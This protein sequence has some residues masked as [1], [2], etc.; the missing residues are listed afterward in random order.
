VRLFVAVEIAD[1]V[2][3]RLA[4]LSAELQKR[5]ARQAR[6]A[7]LT[8]VRPERMHLT[9]RFIGEVDEARTAAIAAALAPPLQTP[10]FDIR[11]AGTGA[12][13]P[14]GRP[15]VLWAGI[16]EGI[17]G[18]QA[19]ERE[20]TERLSGCGVPPEDRPYNP[21]LTLARVR[22]PGGLRS[23]PLFE[24][25]SDSFGTSRVEAITL[26]HSRTSPKGP[27]YFALQRAPLAVT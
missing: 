7:R 17:D 21:H 13:P 27:D 1:G 16:E 5:A 20:V 26:F 6:S 12:F 9:V 10:V 22:D 23:E 19:L 11:I 3:S 25:L 18:L 2:L 4:S 14:R 24:G 8:W 15:R